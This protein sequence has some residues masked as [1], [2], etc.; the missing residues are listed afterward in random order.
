[1]SNH[2]NPRDDSRA[3]LELSEMTLQ[4]QDTDIATAIP[5]RTRPTASAPPRRRARDA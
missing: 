4:S 2:E 5:T 3:S 1:M